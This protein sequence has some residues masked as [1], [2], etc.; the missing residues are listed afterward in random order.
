LKPRTFRELAEVDERVLKEWSASFRISSLTRA[1]ALDEGALFCEV[2]E[3]S[4]SPHTTT[5]G[6]VTLA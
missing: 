4:F 2:D 6:T 5:T 3:R 1:L